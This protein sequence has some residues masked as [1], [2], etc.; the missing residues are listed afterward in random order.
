MP[1]R[2]KPATD[3]LPPALR[4]TRD[5][6]LAYLRVECGL[7][8]NT[9]EAYGRDLRD[10]LDDLRRAGV[11]K[12]DDVT[13]RALVAHV[14]SLSSD[15][16]LAASSVA[17]HL[18]TIKV[19]FRWLHAQ[20]RIPENPADYL[21]QPTRWKRLPSVL[22]PKQVRALLAA[23]RPDPD[24]PDDAPPLWIRDRAILEL[25]YAS[26]LR[27]SEVGTLALA[28]LVRD[29]GVL[30]VT[31]KGDKQR[32]VPMG[33]PARD[34]LDRYLADCRPRLVRE[35]G[36]DLGRVFLSRTGRPLER[37]AV[38]QIVTRH[39]RAAGLEGVHPHV[40]R[41]SFAT[42]L[43]AGGADLRTVQE[44][45]GHADVATTQV[46]THVDRFHLKDVHRK[47]HPRR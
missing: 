37:V 3:T 2:T 7:S 38:W 40:L 32:L 36:R 47:Y 13:P 14:A 41:H 43:L 30:R 29:L 44:L 23:P 17:R 5:T 46:Y 9:L 6:F 1:V 16:S 28:D 15:R 33:V 10:L 34:A 26:G 4:R 18:A 27:A 24:A 19:L 22:S 39:A 12:P 25:L 11:Q 31:G 45:L 20:G 35:D 21:D 42:H 8:A